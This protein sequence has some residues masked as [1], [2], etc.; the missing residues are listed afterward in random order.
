MVVLFI[1][2]EL[3]KKFGEDSVSLY[4]DDGLVFLKN[5]TGR[6]SDKA[7]KQLSKICEQFGKTFQPKLTY[8][9]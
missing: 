7:R 4:R 6:L 9:L 3:T 5:T 2:S 8:K 1:L